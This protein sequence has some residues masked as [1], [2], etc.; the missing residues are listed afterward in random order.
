MAQNNYANKN[1]NIEH[2]RLLSAVAEHLRQPLLYVRQAAELAEDDQSII[3]P[4]ELRSAADAGLMLVEH[5]LSWQRLEQSGEK[6]VS[7][8][9]GLTSVMHQVQGTLQAIAT[10]GQTSLELIVNGR[11][12]PVISD[13]QVLSSALSALA[14]SFIEASSA[15]EHSRV[16]LGVHKT[17]WGLVA[18]V[19]SQSLSVRADSFL[20]HRQ[21][22]GSARQLLP[23]SS[24]SPMSGVA[25]AEALFGQLDVKLRPSKH[26]GMDGLAVTLAPSPQLQ[27]L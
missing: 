12:S 19:Y 13:P 22:V 27:L 14:L 9:V 25:V 17:R 21:L 24:H 10:S 20:R 23:T 16:V 2:E 1:T 8:Q 15:H 6:P 7:A 5:F 3:A 11:Y 26:K 4:A 18:G